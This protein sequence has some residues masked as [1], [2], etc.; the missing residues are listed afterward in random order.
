VLNFRRLL[1]GQMEFAR[2]DLLLRRGPGLGFDFDEKAVERYA[3]DRG[4]PWRTC[5]GDVPG[6]G[7][8]ST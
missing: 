6:A 3:V 2:G 1:D 5:R 4:R 8:R 7:L